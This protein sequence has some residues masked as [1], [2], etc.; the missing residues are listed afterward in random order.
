MHWKLA[1]T[2]CHS[3]SSEKLSAN[4]GEKPLIIIII[5]IVIIIIIIMMMMMMMMMMMREGRA[6]KIV[7]KQTTSK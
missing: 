6:E 3:N 7:N 1:E 2:C 4:A 5:I